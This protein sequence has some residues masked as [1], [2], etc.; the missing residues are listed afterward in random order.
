MFHCDICDKTL[1]TKKNLERHLKL[2]EEWLS[3]VNKLHSEVQEVMSV[4][5]EV[6][7]HEPFA[8]DGIGAEGDIVT[9]VPVDDKSLTLVPVDSKSITIVAADV[10]SL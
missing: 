10:V 2:H 4:K 5:Y 7:A 1:S 8:T 6:T 3:N 9:M